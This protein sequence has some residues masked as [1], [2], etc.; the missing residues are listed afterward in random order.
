MKVRRLLETR[1][2]AWAASNGIPVAWENV[3]F[4]PPAGVYLRA[5]LLRAETRSLDLLGAH[6]R[7]QGV[8]QIN[9]IAPTGAG[10]AQAEAIAEQVCALYPAALRLRESDFELMLV[11]P[12]AMHAPLVD[13]D[14]YT[15]PCSC[16]Y[17]SDHY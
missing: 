10:S 2:S 1:L 9:V 13:A 14:R 15:V 12:M 17:R 8:W 5:F 11:S 3:E 4:T 16:R 6:R 7:L